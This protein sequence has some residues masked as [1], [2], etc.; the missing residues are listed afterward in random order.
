MGSTGRET[1]GFEGYTLD[2]TRGSLR[3]GDREIGLRPKSFALLRYFVENPGRLVSKDEL[4]NALWPNLIVSDESLSQCISDVRHA[5]DDQHR[6]GRR[7]IKNVHGRG[8]LF[9]S[10]VQPPRSRPVDA[11]AAATET[12]QQVGTILRPRLS[13]V[14]LPFIDLSN[15]SDEQYFADGLTDD[16]ITD[17][18]RVSNTFVISRNTAFTYKNKLV[19]TKQIG[20]ELGVRYILEG[21]VRRSRDRVRVNAQLIDSE[22]RAHLWAERYDSCT[23]EVF[24]LQDHITG[25]ISSALHVELIAAEAART[26]PRPDALDCILRGRAVMGKPP[27]IEN[28]ANAIAFFEQALTLDPACVE[29]QSELAFALAA[30]VLDQM[31]DPAIANLSHAETLV[32]QALRTSPR[33]GVAH[34]AKGAVLRALSRPEEACFEYEMATAL[35]PNRTTALSQ[36]GWC[37]LLTGSLQD[38]ISFH[39]RAIRLSPRDPKTGVYYVGIGAVHLFQYRTDEAIMW[40]ERARAATPTLPHAHSYLAAAYALHGEA[41]ASAAALDVARKLRGPGSYRSI[42]RIK[43]LGGYLGVPTVAAQ[44]DATFLAGLRKAGVPEE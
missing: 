7:I 10:P 24:S 27:S 14:V 34:L 8:Y 31:I 42:A 30:R 21:S 44:V 22:T 20:R 29:A 26:V 13:I 3:K 43:N 35:Q 4:I 19:D 36:I 16:L 17:L 12:I 2:L 37:K 18:S 15:E 5:V 33:S 40:L 9:D 1:F 25:Q 6:H 23:D 38:A 41:K 39:E 11:F 28:Y 32:D